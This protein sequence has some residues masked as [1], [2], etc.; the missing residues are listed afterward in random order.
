MPE[1][2]VTSE[3][4]GDKLLSF[5]IRRL[6][7]QHS[8]RSLKRI[9][10]H[11]GC[12]ING[13]TERFASTI[14]GKGDHIALNLDAL[15]SSAPF[16]IE[17]RRIIYEDEG[18]FVYDKPAGINSDEKGILKLLREQIPSLELVH[19]LDRDTTGLLLFAK[20][21]PVLENLIEQFRRY[22][23]KKR[24]EAIVDGVLKIPK[25]IIE[26]EVGKK[27]FYAGQTIWGEVK[28]GKGLY[29][30][31][32]WQRLKIGKA[33]SY[34]ACF[35]KTGRTHQIR[36]HLAGLGHPILGDYQ[37]GKRFQCPYRPSRYLLHAKTL[38][39]SHPLTGETLELDAPLPDDFKVAL[40]K[41]FIL[42]P[43]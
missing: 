30:Y 24:Y 26:N 31:T 21:A 28:R 4:S 9:I 32:E 41:L 16:S 43:A 18:L 34:V 1:W 7:G 22:E 42:L 36:V 10:E 17:P 5:L 11:N 33:V 37:Y 3:E 40:Q 35:P 20:N 2:I 25:G 8:A 12:Q 13:R 15:P 6:E 29:A 38:C 39:F 19:R 23:V 14:L 27:S